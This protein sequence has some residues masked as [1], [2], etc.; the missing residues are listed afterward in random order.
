MPVPLY[1]PDRADTVLCIDAR[2][3]YRQVDRAHREFT[4]EQV[5]FLSNIVRL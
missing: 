4:P 3:I 2:D 1:G 5:E